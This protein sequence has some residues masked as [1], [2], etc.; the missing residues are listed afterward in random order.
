MRLGVETVMLF[1]RDPA[2]GTLIPAPGMPQTVRGG[3]C[4]RSFLAGCPESGRC[5]GSVVV[6]GQP[7]RATLGLLIGGTAL[8][9]VGGTPEETDLAEIERLMPL[10]AAMLAAEQAAVLANA[11][12]GAAAEAADRAG[13]LAGALESARA[14]ASALNA[15]LREEHRRKDEFLAM[16]GHEL[17]NPLA[18][19]MTSIA[20]LRKQ[21]TVWASAQNLIEIMGRQ[22]DQ[23]AR[24]VDDLLD[25]SRVSQGKVEMQRR[26]ML[27]SDAIAGALEESKGF[28]EAHR[29]RVELDGLDAGLTV[30]GDRAR[31]VQVFGNLLN[32]A[33]KYTDP[34]GTI[35]ISMERDGPNAVVRVRDTGIGISPQMQP[36][37]FDL[38]AQVGVALSRAHGGLGIGLTLV[39]TLVELHGGR[40]CVESPGVGSGSTFTVCLPLVAAVTESAVPRAHPGT[41]AGAK[42]L[43]ILIVDDNRDAADS[44]ADLL[45]MLGHHANV[46]YDGESALRL[47]SD[48]RFDLALLDIGLPDIDGCELANRLRQTEA[49]RARLVALT[50]YSTG[51][52]KKRIREAGF[53]AHMVKPISSD[54]LM[55]LL[56][57]TPNQAGA[58]VR[59]SD[60]GSRTAWEPAKRAALRVE[61]PP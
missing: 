19:L 61:G 8:I 48:T 31:L 13:T 33:A 36:R 47:H 4:W 15:Q 29:H 54:A 45:R 55:G 2:L 53:D 7:E 21:G 32:N 42:S 25:V 52:A 12:S 9:L 5:S 46:A 59:N 3:R 49:G 43:R 58:T 23:L 35:S 17:R 40:I 37:I 39:R 30:N 41:T 18:P 20:L 56:A 34:G 26:P 38:F 27:L 50:G 1:V 60:S 16:L 57:S 14:D 22:T 6:S 11:E 28:I 44:M 51:D 24:L 10:V